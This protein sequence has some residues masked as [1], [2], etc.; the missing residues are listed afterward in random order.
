MASTSKWAVG[1][2]T[3]PRAES[4][5]ATTLQSIKNGGWDDFTVFAEP[6]TKI[7][8]DKIVIRPTVYGDWSNWYCAL[9]ELAQTNPNADYLLMFEDDCIMCQ[10]VRQYLEIVV[11]KLDEFAALSFYTPAFY[12]RFS[13][14]NMFNKE[15]EGSRTLGTVTVCMKMNTA[16]DFIS[17]PEISKRRF[18]SRSSTMAAQDWSNTAK[19]VFLGLWAKRKGLPIYYHTPSL[20]QH[21]GQK[22]TLV[23]TYSI[24]DSETQRFALSFMGEDYDAL[25]LLNGWPTA[26]DMKVIPM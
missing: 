21:I 8:A 9:S 11:P 5:I 14:E 18:L 12:N 13:T 1:V 10:N 22:T 26:K 2:V 15:F 6:G 24:Y 19:D 3:A 20:A 25:N 4:Y 7:N 16:L 17:D 23:L